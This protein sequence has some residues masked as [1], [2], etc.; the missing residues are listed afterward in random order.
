MAMP[1]PTR[2]NRE[3][4]VELSSL[5][6][7][8]AIAEERSLTAAGKKINLTQS[9]VSQILKSIESA[10]GV[11]LIDRSARPLRLTLAGIRFHTY[12]E[13]MLSEA[14]KIT[15][16]VRESAR[17][18]L[19]K[20]RLGSID[21]ITSTFGPHMVPQLQGRAEQL[22]LRSGINATMRDA[23]LAR[24]VDLIITSDPFD[25]ED[26]LER[27]EICR[28][29]LL[30]VTPSEYPH[31]SLDGLK[32]L[33]KQ[34]PL[35]R[36]SRRSSLG[37]QIDIHLR[38]LGLEPADRFEIDTSDAVL[39][40]VCASPGWAVSSAICLLQARHFIGKARAT[41]LPGP[42]ATRRIYLIARQGEHG[43]TPRQ[44]AQICRSVMQD[45]LL[46]EISLLAPWLDQ[47]AFNIALDIQDHASSSKYSVKER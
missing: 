28:D 16:S 17:T 13:S 30:V 43:D 19:P 44:V 1:A 42:T 29:P 22:T 2:Q 14:R 23:L 47:D 40:M 33:A 31:L 34:L 5:A 9:A 39:S 10:M 7:F 41:H 26:H 24:E 38:R 12:A 4:F 21:S 45:K 25:A 46:P 32:G 15:T 36:Y 8:S 3:Q 18:S 27:H 20:I 37:V 6:V 11:Q 35:I